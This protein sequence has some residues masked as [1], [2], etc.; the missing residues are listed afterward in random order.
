MIEL[1]SFLKAWSQYDKESSWCKESDIKIFNFWNLQLPS[2]LWF[3]QFI[4]H[5]FGN[6][7]SKANTLALFSVMGDRRK[8]RLNRSRV[9]IF[10][11]G[12]NT[13]IWNEYNDHCIPE[14]D[15]SLGF[16]YI[17]AE[18]YLRFPLW[19]LYI[20]DPRSDY[21]SVKDSV[22]KMS[23]VNIKRQTQPERFC[24]LVCRHDRNGIRTEIFNLLS[25][26]E[27]IDSGGLFLNNTDELREVYND[28][29]LQ[30]IKNYKFNICP[31]NSNTL[32][33]VTEKLF[34]SI[35]AG[36]IPIYWGNENPEPE[37][38]N[39]DA[40]L[41]YKGS[42]NASEMIKQVSELQYNEK[43]YREFVSQ[44]TFLPTAAEYIWDR[45]NTLKGHLDKLIKQ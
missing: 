43:L 26:I 33:Y 12:E 31:E 2:D 29:K 44:D 41:F 32:G 5:H 25:T 10:F 34:E 22:H 23:I 38:I 9:K 42:A 14:V 40:I 3:H 19:L 39:K 30:Y 18:N 16:E 45:I 20:L 1:M 4:D 13:T 21:Q 11:T 28:Q 37:V 6:R 27:H 15:L 35:S 36:C 17:E 24:S 7:L 8:I